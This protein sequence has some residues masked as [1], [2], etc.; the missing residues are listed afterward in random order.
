MSL[1][2]VR[3]SQPKPK[4]SDT[5]VY[6]YDELIESRSRYYNSDDFEFDISPVEKE[7]YFVEIN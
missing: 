1:E 2:K 3:G 4:I 5:R 6:S 7:F